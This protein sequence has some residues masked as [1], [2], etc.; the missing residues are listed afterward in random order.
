MECSDSFVWLNIDLPF[1]AYG[2]RSISIAAAA[3]Q[4]CSRCK[5]A[6][7]CDPSPQKGRPPPAFHPQARMQ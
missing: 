1:P 2:F 4:T 6:E 5:T 3:A 7:V